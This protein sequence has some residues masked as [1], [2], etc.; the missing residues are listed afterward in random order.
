MGIE[1]AIAKYKQVIGIAMATVILSIIFVP[2]QTA[3]AF[4]V[5]LDLPNSEDDI[6]T[7]S[8]AGESFEITIEVE[9][10]ELI[11]ISSVELILDNDEPSV[12]RTVFDSDG[13]YSSGSTTLVIGNEIEIEST[14]SLDD[15]GYGYGYGIVSDGTTFSPNYSYSFTYANGFIGGNSYG[16]SI[17]GTTDLVTGLIGPGTITIRGEIRTT[18]LEEGTHTL[19][20]LIRTGAGGN[21]E[22]QL[23]APQLS[24]EVEEGEDITEVF[25][26]VPLGET[27]VDFTIPGYGSF[28][29]KFSA[30]TTATGN[31]VVTT[32]DA[33][34]FFNALTDALKVGFKL[35]EGVEGVFLSDDANDYLIAGA[36][37]DIDLS[38][39]GLPPGTE[40]TLGLPY[41][42][43]GFSTSE[44]KRL[45]LF[46]FND[47][48]DEWEKLTND[49]PSVNGGDEVDTDENVV[50]G[51]TDDFSLFAPA[52]EVSSSKPSVSKGGG[53]TVIV[54]ETFPPSYFI[55]HPLDRVQI[56]EASVFTVGGSA[57]LQ[58]KPGQ[59]VTLNAG[60]KNFQTT[61]QDYAIIFQVIDKDGFTSDIGWVTGTLPPGEDTEA[62]RSWTV[63]PTGNY[64]IKIFVWDG[65][66]D[67]PVPLSEVTEK[68][69]TSS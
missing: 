62:S 2:F 20:A 57:V 48:T 6:V 52:F 27:E 53:G 64:T 60:F 17:A 49:D 69:F 55:D 5:D 13:I 67:L 19:D 42:D 26:E 46:H 16:Y 28:E 33:D 31:V 66:S 25:E 4:T 15:T 10:G 40:V 32:Q 22:D 58:A 47:D 1:K 23:V 34:A 18:D 12:K 36:I 35:D 21:G 44:E 39:L 24:F 43:A 63:G 56:E 29:L 8:A 3:T 37:S 59:Q 54:N 7:Q 45:R 11:S 65:V 9:A 68:G 61:N 14:S 41:I 51:T 30:A 50:Y 38:A